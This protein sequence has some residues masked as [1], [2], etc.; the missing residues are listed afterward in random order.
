VRSSSP[1]VP[2]GIKKMNFYLVIGR[3]L[4][5]ELIMERAQRDSAKKT[6]K[7]RLNES[8]WPKIKN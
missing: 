4:L 8:Q 3:T 6:S 7:L 1:G 5:I 2:L